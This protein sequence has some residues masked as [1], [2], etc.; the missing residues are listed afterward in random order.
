MDQK[1]LDNLGSKLVDLRKANGF[2]QSELA[3]MLYITHQAISQ[4]ETKHESYI[5]RLDALE[6]ELERKNAIMLWIII[7]S[8]IIVLGA[9]ITTCIVLIKRKNKKTLA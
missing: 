9:G 4:W 2:T 3:D 8:S 1:M 7:A 6:K 5:A